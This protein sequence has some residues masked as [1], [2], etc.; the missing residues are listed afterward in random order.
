M[1]NNQL[2][3]NDRFIPN[4][5]DR[6]KLIPGYTEVHSVDHIGVGHYHFVTPMAPA[7]RKSEFIYLQPGLH[8]IDVAV[9]AVGTMPVY[10]YYGV[11]TIELIEFNDA[12]SIGGMVPINVTSIH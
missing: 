11:L 2:F 12:A 4:T 10:I 3:Y 1:V 5:A 7:I 8:V 6:Y 9:R